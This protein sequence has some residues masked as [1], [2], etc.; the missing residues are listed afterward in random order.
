MTEGLPEEEGEDLAETLSLGDCEPQELTLGDLLLLMLVLG[1]GEAV[2]EA[3]SLRLT[4]GKREAEGVL[5][6]KK[7]KGAAKL[8]DGDLLVDRVKLP[9]ALGEGDCKAHGLDL[10][11][12]LML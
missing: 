9:V 6:R 1:Q 5:V 11:V 7:D 8:V 2:A 10:C 4:L 12:V 3:L